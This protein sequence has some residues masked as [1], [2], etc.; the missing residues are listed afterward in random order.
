MPSAIAKHSYF[1]VILQ[2]KYYHIMR[3]YSRAYLAYVYNKN[4]YHIYT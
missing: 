4:T 2:Y 1:I 3:V